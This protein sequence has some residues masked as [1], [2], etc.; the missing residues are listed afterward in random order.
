MSQA[1]N[2]TVALGFF[3]HIAGELVVLFI[4]ISFLVALLQRYI[5]QETIKRILTKPH[6][7]LQN[8]MGA[9][10]GAITPFCSCS[11]IP[12]LVGLFKSG[13]PFGGTI[14]FL[15]TSPVLNP[16]I[17]ILFMKFFGVKITIIYSVVTFVFAV[18]IGTLLEKLGMENQVKNV[19]IKGG[20]NE[21]ITYDVLEGTP[22]E[23]HMEVFKLSIRDT[24][25]LFVKVL[26]FLF[27]G[28]GVGAFIYGFVPESFI[29][30]VAGP[31]NLFAVPVSAIIGVP[32]YVRTETMIPIAKALN[33]S[34][35]S[36]GAIM[37]LII[38]G[39]G[40]SI[41]EVTLLNTIFKKK[42]VIAFVVSVFSVAT[43]T[44]YIFNIFN[45]I[46]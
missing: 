14:S 27:V 10:L 18:L 41:P 19:A 25:S 9:A 32:M 37:A 43:I 11:T 30:K 15:I 6:K 17:I 2:L 13:A 24:F 33:A 12:I 39:A 23:K 22:M 4:A 40:A 7:G 35:M 36:M 16:M 38:G 34:G 3:K 29:V 28:A 31:D 26:P 20:H 1:N 8:I 45:V 46:Q 42:M 5:S 44:G 21:E